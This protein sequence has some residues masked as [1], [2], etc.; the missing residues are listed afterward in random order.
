MSVFYT[1]WVKSLWRQGISR[2]KANLSMVGISRKTEVIKIKLMHPFKGAL[3]PSDIKEMEIE[4]PLSEF[5]SF[6]SKEKMGLLVNA[7]KKAI[8][9]NKIIGIG[10]TLKGMTEREQKK[11]KIEQNKIFAQQKIVASEGLKEFGLAVALSA[12]SQTKR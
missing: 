11:Y 6:L 7:Y 1:N 10:L 9:K 3:P 2:H 5:A 12:A 8:T 4:I